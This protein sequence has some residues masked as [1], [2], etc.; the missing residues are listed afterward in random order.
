[1]Q[2]VTF[3]FETEQPT[4]SV[5]LAAEQERQLV[6]VMAQAILAVL[7]HHHEEEHEPT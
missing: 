6:E 7:N 4:P 2:Q 1:M 5:P 3:A